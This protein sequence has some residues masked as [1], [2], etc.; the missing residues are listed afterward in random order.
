MGWWER[1]DGE[2]IHVRTLDRL[3]DLAFLS[4]YANQCSPEQSEWLHLEIE[5]VVK[6]LWPTEEKRSSIDFVG[7]AKQMWRHLGGSVTRRLLA[8]N[9]LMIEKGTNRAQEWI[10]RYLWQRSTQD[11]A[12]ELISIKVGN[13]ENEA[14]TGSNRNERNILVIAR[15]QLIHE[16]S[17]WQVCVESNPS[18]NLIVCSLDAMASQD[19]LQRRPREAN[20]FA[21]ETLT[22]TISSDDPITFSTSLADEYAYAWAGMVLRNN[23]AYDPSYARGVLDQA[24]ATSMRMRFTIP[25]KDHAKCGSQRIIKAGSHARCT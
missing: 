5:K 18:S 4:E 19:F 9:R 20:G 15:A 8:Y 25:D 10:Y 14:R 3:L 16:M 6:V 11:R 21:D 17:R 12:H 24:A 7:T 23:E 2:V 1:H 13:D 22:W